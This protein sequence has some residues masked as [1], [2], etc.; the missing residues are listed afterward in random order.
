MSWPLAL[1]SPVPVTVPVMTTGPG[2]FSAP[3][4]TSSACKAMDEDATFFEFASTYM[5]PVVGSMT[6]V[7]VIPTCGV[8]SPQPMS[9]LLLTVVAPAARSVRR[10]NQV[11]LPQRA[12]VRSRIVVGVKRVHAVAF[13]GHETT[14]CVPLPGIERLAR[15][16]GCAYTYPFTGCEKSLPKVLTVTFW[17]VRIVSFVFAPLRAL[18]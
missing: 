3:V 10:V 17:G 16:S 18:S 1:P 4:V 5:V 11:R 8:R 14:L 2:D 9:E 13:G 7:L 12:R 15:Y 6:G